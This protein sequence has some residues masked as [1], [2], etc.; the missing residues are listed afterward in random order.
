M[1]IAQFPP[2]RQQGTEEMKDRLFWIHHMEKTLKLLLSNNNY[3][4][5]V[6]L[7]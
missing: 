6:Q 1:F 7:N 3:I 2:G 5:D 4:V